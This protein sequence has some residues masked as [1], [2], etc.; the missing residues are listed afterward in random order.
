MH[1]LRLHRLF[2]RWT[3]G[4][5]IVFTLHH[6]RPSQPNDFAPNYLL[7]I[8]PDFL[9]RVILLLRRE[10]IDIVTLDEALIRLEKGGRR[11]AAFTFDDGYRDVRDHAVPV[12][13]RHDA[14]STH[15]ITSS[16]ADGTGDL[17]WLRLERA[18]AAADV[19]K[20]DFG[21]GPEEFRA[22]NTP[23]KYAAWE[24][25]Y[26]RLRDMDEMSMRRCI[27]EME[28]NAGTKWDGLTSS[29][30]M[31]W[32]EL[33]ELSADHRHTIGSHTC[34]HYRL[35]KL[36]EAGVR[37][38]IRIGQERI[39]QELGIVPRHF[40]YPVGDPTSAGPRE[41]RIA[42]ESGLASAWTTRLGTLFP[43]HSG[44]CTALPRVSLNGHYQREDYV[45]MFLSG[46]PF[47]LRN[48]FRK[49]DVA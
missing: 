12:L 10:R 8:S 4:Q 20:A 31:N 25:V 39:Q 1:L 29:L 9:E 16:F 35:A 21:K 48:R 42:A 44:H 19:V 30:C 27:D 41:F 2:G 40:A 13:R 49:L 23:E 14:P 47:A 45:E 18:I 32:D 36:D 17:W 6:V 22:S 7:E 34:T 46:A 26:W 5:G 28:R 33:R 37:E 43:A 3:R 11:F 38:E 15:F 24:Q